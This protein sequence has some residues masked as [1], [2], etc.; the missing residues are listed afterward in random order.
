MT[1]AELRSAL[2]RTYHAFFGRHGQPRP[3]QLGAARP[4]LD[5]RDVLLM[6]PAAS[7]KTEAACAPLCEL[8]L[9]RE[10]EPPSVLVVSPTRALA[11]DLH[12]RLEGPMTELGISLGRWTGERKEPAAGRRSGRGVEL[13]AVTLVT[14]ESLDSL[15]SRRPER[16]GT[17]EGVVLDELHVLDGTTRGDQLRILLGRLRHLRGNLRAVAVSATIAHP[18]AVA[19]RY[20]RDA[21]LVRDDRRH[22]IKA[23]LVRGRAPRVVAR[24]LEGLCRQGRTRKVLLFADRRDLVEEYA[25]E[26]RSMPVFQGAVFAHHGSLSRAVR[27]A[28]E[29]RFLAAPRALCVATMTLELGIDIGDIDVVGL[30]APPP[31]VSSLLQ[32]IGR[33][34]R[35]GVGP[36]ALCF[37]VHDASLFRYRTLL[38]LA[39]SGDLAADPACFHPS[40]LVQQVLSLLHENPGRWVSASA[41]HR[42][43]DPD[44]ASHWPT[45]RIEGLLKHL[46]RDTEWLEQAGGGRY[47]AGER[48]ERL[49]QRG[50]LHSNI[51]TQEELEVVDQLTDQVIG[52]VA[53]WE[54]GPALRLG[55][56][57]RQVVRAD[58]RRIVV[59][60]A[61]S[62]E[63]PRFAPRGVPIVGRA[64]ARAHG[65]RLGVADGSWPLA[66]REDGAA[67]LFHFGGTAWGFLVSAA[68]VD[69]ADG[70]TPRLPA[71]VLDAGPFAV[72]LAQPSLA[73]VPTFDK[74]ALEALCRRQRRRLARVLAMGPFHRDLP[75]DDADAALL[76]AADVAGLAAELS[77]ACICEPP[78]GAD[79]AVW[80]ELA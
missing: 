14:P 16:L 41:L 22:P 12:R 1:G 25:A 69:L 57:G 15:L 31:D 7:G 80:A 73:R 24:H 61:A 48:T 40:V 3:I 46:A 63:A 54:R 42:R 23:R 36:R 27:E 78:P 59:G 55:G 64:L 71:P 19:G 56:R 49:W 9:T 10:W 32:R 21:V 74:E 30:L 18:G 38:D 37:A 26:L 72:T 77:R 52:A 34:G 53:R 67:L 45:A 79:P 50:R 44:L 62:G 65:A 33:S 47:V 68:L 58:S 51:E 75:L 5:G 60:T 35:R 66:V 11:N 8:L 39:A 2:P 13:P 4:L 76:E 29:E 28:T 17:V 70:M 20:L 43:L 6:A